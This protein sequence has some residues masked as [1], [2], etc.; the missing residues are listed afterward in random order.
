MS[1][2]NDVKVLAGIFAASAT[3]HVIRPQT[4]EPLMPDYVPAHR[5]VIVW[6]GVLEAALAA[7]LLVPQTRRLAG[8]GS[9]AVLL[10]VMPAH[11]HGVQSSVAAGSKPMAAGHLARMPLQIPMLRAAWRATR[12]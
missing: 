12:G 3:V 9:I 6:S 7:G 2:P 4:F 5:E 1:A 8:W 10:G 11:V